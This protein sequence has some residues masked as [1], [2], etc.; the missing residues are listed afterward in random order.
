[1]TTLVGIK[2]SKEKEGVILA[3]DLSRTRTEW[4][5][6]GNIAFKQQTKHEGQKIYVDNKREIAICMSGVLDSIYMDL[7][8]DV[9]D[10]KINLEKAIKD[11]F[12]EE[13]LK[14]NLRRWG[15]YIPNNEFRNAIYGVFYIPVLDEE[16]L[17]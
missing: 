7:L 6:Q 1:M 12:F 3:S 10:N 5:P 17:L 15:G 16:L 4:K 13:L 9:L 8:S 14:T 11:E 2:A